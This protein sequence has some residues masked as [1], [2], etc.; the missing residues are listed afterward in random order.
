MVDPLFKD[1][2]KPFSVYRFKDRDDNQE[3]AD[4][5]ELRYLELSK[6]DINKPIEN[7]SK[8][9]QVAL[10][11]RCLG[12]EGMEAIVAKLQSLGNEVINMTLPILEKVNSDAQIREAAIAREIWQ[13]DMRTE[14]V[15][16][17][18]RGRAEGIAEGKLEVAKNMLNKNIDLETISE[19]T[20]LTKE[21]ISAL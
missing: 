18:R 12:T 2:K 17:E 1:S 7:M 10:W 6:V 9:E 3:L 4:L 11:L 13:K 5:C 19:V 14:L 15:L 16:S 8:I 21:E 20:G